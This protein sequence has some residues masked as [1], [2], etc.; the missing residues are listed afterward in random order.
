MTTNTRIEYSGSW[1]SV[2][3]VEANERPHVHRVTDREPGGPGLDGQ[4]PVIQLIITKPDAGVQQPPPHL[5]RG[6]DLVGHLLK[7][8]HLS[9]DVSNLS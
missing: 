2:V 3:R 6:L 7:H 8:P 4:G 1:L 9:D 5:L